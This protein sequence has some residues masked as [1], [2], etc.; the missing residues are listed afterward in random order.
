MG[1]VIYKVKLVVV[2]F[3]LKAA[4]WPQSMRKDQIRLIEHLNSQN[5]EIKEQIV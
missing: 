1:R 5:Q 4:V 3:N 2:Y